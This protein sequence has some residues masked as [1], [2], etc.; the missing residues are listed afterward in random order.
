MQQMFDPTMDDNYGFGYEGYGGKTHYGSSYYGSGAKW[1]ST[2]RQKER[3]TLADFLELL[4]G[5][6]EM[7]GRIIIMTTNQR[8]KMDS[9]LVR[10]GRIDL[11][12]ELRP[13]SRLLI[14]HIFRH[15]YKHEEEEKLRSIFQKYFEHLSEKTVSTARVINCFMYT[16]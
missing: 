12:V 8:E 13:P 2:W 9:A 4:D 7:D 15:M 10:P 5:I 1:G 3:V 11:D 14:G 6:V 16:N